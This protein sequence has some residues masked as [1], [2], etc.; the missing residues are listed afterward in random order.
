MNIKR[1]Y[2]LMSSG[3]IIFS[4]MHVGAFSFST[5]KKYFC[6]QHPK[7]VSK[8]DPKTVSKQPPKIVSKQDLDYKLIK[9]NVVK[10]IPI[11]QDIIKTKGEN[12]T[13]EQQNDRSCKIQLAT[14]LLENLYR[15]YC[16]KQYEKRNYYPAES[17][18]VEVAITENKINELTDSWDFLGYITSF[19][20][21]ARFTGYVDIE[22]C[23]E[24][25]LIAMNRLNQ[26]I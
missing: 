22:G 24:Y 25:F 20:R 17:H 19:F 13:P 14:D 4:G 9:D 10:V 8:Q 1:L 16:M 7:T 2:V 3:I 23:A 11:L 26:I 12:L 18:R 6:K 5:I 15:E 21:A